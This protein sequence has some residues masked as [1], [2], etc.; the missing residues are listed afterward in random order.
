MKFSI[1]V[2][3]KNLKNDYVDKFNQVFKRIT[4]HNGSEFSKLK[5]L[6]CIGS[7]INFTSSYS[8]GKRGTN[9]NHN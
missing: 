7:K 8:S 4:S 9:E 5:T 3:L 6:E 1:M 2:T